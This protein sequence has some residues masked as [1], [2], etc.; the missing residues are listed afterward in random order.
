MDFNCIGGLGGSAVAFLQHDRHQT[1]GGL[2]RF[3]AGLGFDLLDRVVPVFF[4]GFFGL[5]LGFAYGRH[6]LLPVVFRE[7]GGGLDHDGRFRNDRAV[8]AA[9]LRMRD[10]LGGLDLVH[11]VQAFDDL[12]ENAVG[13]AAAGR[14]EHSV[15]H[16]VNEKLAG[17]GVGVGR[18]G[19]GDGAAHV[20]ESVL[21][22]VLD[23]G[24]G[25]VFLLD[26]RRVTAALDHEV[27]HDAV[28]D[29]AVIEL[30]LDV[31]N[32]VVGADGG[33]F[34]VQFKDD[35]AEGGFELDA[36]GE[37]GCGGGPGVG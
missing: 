28:E 19:H 36:R 17:G 26:F 22:L 27:G 20:F 2:F 6:D 32:K 34:G 12:A 9:I 23:R 25:G 35:V 21:P 29:E 31:H 11:G 7:C 15:V 24:A 16:D 1:R 13:G 37:R 8:G 33:F 30:V 10:A 4:A 3:L 5:F 14:V 18:A